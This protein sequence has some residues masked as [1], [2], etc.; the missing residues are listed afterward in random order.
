MRE[1]NEIH[2]LSYSS[3]ESD[4][5]C[6][7]VFSHPNEVWGLS[8]S[9]SDASVF[10]SIS[11]MKTGGEYKAQLWKMGDTADQ[12]SA[13]LDSDAR[14]YNDL[15]EIAALPRHSG[16]IKT[17]QVESSSASSVLSVDDSSVNFWNVDNAGTVYTTAS[18]LLVC[19]WRAAHMHKHKY[20]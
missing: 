12:A 13:S 17:V 3:K 5:Q 16:V 10:W 7:K 15:K 14:T 8:T 19:S 9:P 4:L 11:Q 2:V 1:D 6:D 20:I 18:V